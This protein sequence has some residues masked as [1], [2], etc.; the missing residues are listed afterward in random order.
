MCE[1]P[2]WILEK[3]VTKNVTYSIVNIY[4][5]INLEKEIG[6]SKGNVLYILLGTEDPVPQEPGPGSLPRS[7]GSLPLQEYVLN[8][9]EEWVV[10]STC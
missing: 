7:P 10:F 6:E 1:C 5:S 3:L 9:T 8:L 4:K 2:A